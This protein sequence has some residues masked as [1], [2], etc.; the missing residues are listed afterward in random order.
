MGDRVVG[1][2]RNFECSRFPEY[3][4]LRRPVGTS[5]NVRS[6]RRANHNRI[7]ATLGTGLVRAEALSTHTFEPDLALKHMTHDGARF[8]CALPPLGRAPVGTSLCVSGTVWTGVAAPATAPERV[9]AA[10]LLTTRAPLLATSAPSAA[11]LLYIPIPTTTSKSKS[12]YVGSGADVQGCVCLAICIGMRPC[13][14]RPVCL[15][16]EHCGRNKTTPNGNVVLFLYPE[17]NSSEVW[18]LSLCMLRR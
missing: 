9:R 18:H 8:T 16:G 15:R 13:Q 5:G 2:R 10:S 17:I 6:R 4:I 1:A 14:C 12:A 3:A 11:P 7:K